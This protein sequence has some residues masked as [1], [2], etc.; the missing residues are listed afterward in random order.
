MAVAEL[1][2]YGFDYVYRITNKKTGKE[3]A[4]AKIGMVFFDLKTR[5]V[6]EVPEKFRQ[7]C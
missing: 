2:K 5:P 1:N 3:I 6:A 7:V 4:V